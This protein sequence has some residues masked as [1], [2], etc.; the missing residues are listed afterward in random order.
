M[1]YFKNNNLVQQTVLI[2]TNKINITQ[3]EESFGYN[4]VF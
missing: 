2:N 4:F 3:R 1:K